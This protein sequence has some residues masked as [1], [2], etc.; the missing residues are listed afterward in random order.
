M[1][2][3][4]RSSGPPWTPYGPFV[5]PRGPPWT[6]YGPLTETFSET[7]FEKRVTRVTSLFLV[8]IVVSSGFVG[9]G[10]LIC[11]SLIENGCDRTAPA[12][13]RRSRC[14]R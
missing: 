1:D 12:R 9:K 13:W 5:R 2:P 4:V 10:N 14:G 3:F 7:V 6:P 11:D 8:F